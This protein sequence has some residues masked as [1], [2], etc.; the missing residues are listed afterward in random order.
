MIVGFHVVALHGLTANTKN[1]RIEDPKIGGSRC[2]LVG[3]RPAAGVMSVTTIRKHK[4]H[5]ILRC[6]CFQIVVALNRAERGPTSPA[7]SRGNFRDLLISLS[8][9]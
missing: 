1:R 5:L 9:V 4:H 3:R 2:G 6:L 8:P 7:L